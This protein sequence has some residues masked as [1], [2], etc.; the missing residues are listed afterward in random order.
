[1][2]RLV[3]RM[4][5]I[6]DA[7]MGIEADICVFMRENGKE[8]LNLYSREFM[9]DNAD[10]ILSSDQCRDEKRDLRVLAL[11]VVEGT[12][13]DDVLEL[14][15]APLG[16]CGN[17]LTD[18]EVAALFASKGCND[19]EGGRVCYTDTL[20]RSKN[21]TSWETAMNLATILPF[22]FEK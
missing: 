22:Y 20:L 15:V 12:A 11:R 16:F 18:E 4:T 3:K 1:M 7:V 6:S 2:E 13:G 21:I 14:L 8:Y 9:E 5:A 10:E 19:A 17:V